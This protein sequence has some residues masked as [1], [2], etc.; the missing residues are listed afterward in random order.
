MRNSIKKCLF[1]SLFILL[2]VFA[3]AEEIIVS[4]S[5]F[6]VESENS[7][8]KYIGKGISTLVAGELRRTRA[9]K[10]L[11]RSQMN[12]ILEEQKFSLSGLVDESQQV[13]L[14]RQPYGKN[15]NLR[16]YWSLLCTIDSYGT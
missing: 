4:V 6:N 16:L 2:I 15:R 9:I 14:G 8:F 7:K 3:G 11:E 10:L 13:E 12:K 5:D 1:L